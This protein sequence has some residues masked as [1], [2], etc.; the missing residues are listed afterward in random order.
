MSKRVFW[1]VGLPALLHW[2]EA[3][4]LMMLERHT[5]HEYTRWRVPPVKVVRLR[6]LMIEKFMAE[7]SEPTDTL[8]MVDVDHDHPRDL[9][10]RLVEFNN[11]PIHTSLTFK[12]EPT[13]PVAC[14]MDYK[15][16]FESGEVA[17]HVAQFMPGE[18]LE[19]DRG[20]HAAIAVQRQVYQA[21]LHLGYDFKQMYQYVGQR[22]CDEYFAK[23]CHEA[24]FK[25][26]VNTGIVSPHRSD[27]QVM[28]GLKEWDAYMRRS[29][30]GG[31]QD[32]PTQ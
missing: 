11:L 4:M 17:H 19:C 14:A 10:N 3:D 32:G 21:I 6:P 12:R 16:G 20:G 15:K 26:Y 31:I 8:V 25:Q 24:G 1:F 29:N 30:R 22:D 13:M 9:I 2:W 28:I 23:L 18:I 27:V 5:K 7:T